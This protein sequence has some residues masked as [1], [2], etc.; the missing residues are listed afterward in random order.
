MF[1]LFERREKQRKVQELKEVCPDIS[2]EEAAQALEMCGGKEEDAAAALTSDPTFLRRVKIACGTAPAPIAR[3][4]SG[5]SSW[6]ARPVGPRPKLIDPATLGDS[7]FVGAFRGKGF[8]GSRK[9]VLKPSQR[10]PGRPTRKRAD[11]D[12]A[13]PSSGAESPS[14]T[15]RDEEAVAEVPTD[16][17]PAAEDPYEAEAHEGAA[18]GDA[19]DMETED[20]AKDGQP[21][22]EVSPK[23]TPA[24]AVKPYALVTE[25]SDG[26]LRPVTDSEYKRAVHAVR[27]TK[28]SDDDGDYAPRGTPAK[29]A[30]DQAPRDRPRRT[31]RQQAPKALE[32]PEDVVKELES[33]AD[34][35]A[36]AFL[37]VQKDGVVS[38]ALTL[39]SQGDPI[40][41][42]TLRELMDAATADAA[43][44][45]APG[46]AAELT[47]AAPE[48]S[49]AKEVPQEDRKP[50]E[51]EESAE[52]ASLGDDSA[53]SGETTEEEDF[54]PPRATRRQSAG[55]PQR[56]A[57]VAALV[58][59]RAAEAAADAALAE[60]EEDTSP[61]RSTRAAR[62][63]SLGGEMTR[64][65]ADA[66]GSR[67]TGT[68][69]RSAGK[70]PQQAPKR[71]K[72]LPDADAGGA[73]SEPS[74]PVPPVEGAPG[75]AGGMGVGRSTA[76][77]SRGHTNRGRVKQKSHKSAD[78]V[79]VGQVRAH[80]G[81]YN[82]GYIFPAGFHSRT[83]FRSSVALDSLCV[84]ECYVVGQ[85][86]KYWPAPTFKVVALDRPEEPII[87]KSCTGCWTG[88]LKRINAEIEARRRAGEDLPPPPKTAI[89][90]PEYFGFNQPDIME[91]VE[92][93]DEQH[94]CTEYWAGKQDRQRAAAGLVVAGPAPQ[95]APRAPSGSVRR[96]G[97]GGGRRRRGSGDDSDSGGVASD[98]EGDETQYMTNRWSAVSRSERY[99]KRLQDNG[100]EAGAAEVD[101]DNPLPDLIDPIT[102]EPVVRPAISPYGHVMGAATWKAVLAES[103]VCPFTKKPL[104]WE[105][106]RVL[107]HNNIDAYK[108]QI[109]L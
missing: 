4:A 75:A 54:M 106:C 104:R 66:P 50:A 37:A 60:A 84:H 77:S 26:Q 10:A 47:E 52:E 71:R 2:D 8:E 45:A 24:S 41:A 87:A 23:P 43:A 73:A 3:Q 56:A 89:A 72:S 48:P 18:G 7:V 27:H 58:S 53:H 1:E 107:T 108:D 5:K 78:L 64:M 81:W 100:D 30:Q 65:D 12:A 17:A 25:T 76:I 51:E 14:D 57:R 97:G 98:G 88:I 61:A 29:A 19:S 34:G 90:G 86:G 59:M 82:A 20:A 79:A 42:I 49:P 95:R 15:E 69:K 35:D 93:L 85:G 6:S 68:P 67:G 9:P 46:A 44:V 55:R 91:A 94:A 99:R 70:D 32:S 36:V 105:Q 96:T 40:R 11:G 80:K 28:G 16:Q 33:M 83:L 63:R 31:C 39:M 13:G 21:N 38:A 102:L 62:R 92:K 74:G 22:G 101:P 103:G 109:I